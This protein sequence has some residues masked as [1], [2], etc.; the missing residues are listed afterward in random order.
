MKYCAVIMLIDPMKTALE[1][2]NWFTFKTGL[3]RKNIPDKSDGID[4]PV[5]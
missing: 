5:H 2:Q 4:Y 3:Q 1:K